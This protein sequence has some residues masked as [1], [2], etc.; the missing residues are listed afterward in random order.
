MVL[1]KKSPGVSNYS[2]SEMS[3]ISAL[4]IP[5]VFETY[6]RIS[7]RVVFYGYGSTRHVFLI[8]Q[9][10]DFSVWMLMTSPSMPCANDS[11]GI[12]TFTTMMLSR[13]QIIS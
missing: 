9:K 12:M 5:I 1:W 13:D 11:S 10:I 4:I 6:V 3:N 8:P 2:P 7:I